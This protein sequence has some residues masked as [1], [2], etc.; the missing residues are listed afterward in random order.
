[1]RARKTIPAS[2]KETDDSF[3]LPASPI[4]SNIAARAGSSRAIA[5]N[6]DVS[7]II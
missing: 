7:T 3:R 2:S 1:M 5:I 4:A 6:A